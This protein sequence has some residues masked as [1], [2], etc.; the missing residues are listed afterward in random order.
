MNQQKQKRN[1]QKNPFVHFH[2]Y[3]CQ[4]VDIKINWRNNKKR[5]AMMTHTKQN[6]KK[7]IEWK[8]LQMIKQK[9]YYKST[10]KTRKKVNNFIIFSIR[11]VTLQHKDKHINLQSNFSKIKKREQKCNCD[12]ERTNCK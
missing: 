8:K 12:Q 7:V 4:D 9:L 5:K 10:T 2:E 11:N 1:Y 3:V 6:K